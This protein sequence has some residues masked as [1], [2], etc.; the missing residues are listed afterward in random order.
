[1]SLLREHF[2]WQ[3]LLLWPSSMSFTPQEKPYLLPGI[4]CRFKLPYLLQEPASSAVPSA[5][6]AR[7]CTPISWPSVD[8]WLIVEVQSWSTFCKPGANHL[9]LWRYKVQDFQLKSIS[10]TKAVSPREVLLRKLKLGFVRFNKKSSE[11]LHF[12][13]NPA[14]R[15]IKDAWRTH[16]VDRKSN[17]NVNSVVIFT[18][19][20]EACFVLF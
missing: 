3:F 17:A 1:M 4:W 19:E 16:A 18:H 20:T 7:L 6:W 10:T 13:A 9:Y 8:S 5:F 12:R 2:D 11:F 15:T 14:P